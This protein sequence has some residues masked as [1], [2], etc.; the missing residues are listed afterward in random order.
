MQI[1]KPILQ[2]NFV[3]LLESFKQVVKP[4]SNRP[5]RIKKNQAIEVVGCGLWDWMV[6]K[7][8]FQQMTVGSLKNLKLVIPV[9]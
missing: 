7:L 8:S 6:K 9:L 2:L 5:P 4:T 3:K 1:K